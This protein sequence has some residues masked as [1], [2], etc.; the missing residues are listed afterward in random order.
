VGLR[1]GLDV[2][3]KRGTLPCREANSGR[4]ARSLVTALMMAVFWYVTLCSLVEVY[5][6]FR[7]AYSLQPTSSGFIALM[8]AAESTSESIY[9]FFITLLSLVAYPCAQDDPFQPNPN[10]KHCILYLIQYS[11]Y[12]R[13]RFL[14]AASI[15]ITVFWDVAPCSMLEIDRRS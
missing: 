2:A 5:R 6:R 12:V 14:T 3:V 11:D 13:F 7:G 4:P 1:A 8:M 15:K 10:R 9:I